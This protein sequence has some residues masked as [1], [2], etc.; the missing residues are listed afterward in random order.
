M[1][2]WPNFGLLLAHRL[3]HSPSS[4][5]TLSQRLMFAGFGDHFFYM[6][7]L[8]PSIE[9]AIAHGLTKLFLFQ[10]Q[11]KHY[12][13]EKKR[14]AKEL[15][16]TLKDPSVIVMADWLKIRGTLKGWTKLWCVLK[17]GMLVMYKSH[18]QKVSSPINMGLAFITIHL[19]SGWISHY[20]QHIALAQFCWISQYV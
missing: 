11:K 2:R 10:V 13:R 14:A 20:I 17:P 16:S 6:Y 9:E 4:K 19:K 5:P 7:L 15:L 3:R 1:R 12:R 18:K 8:F